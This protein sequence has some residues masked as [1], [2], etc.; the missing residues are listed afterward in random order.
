MTAKTEQARRRSLDQALASA[1]IEGHAPST[2][3]LADCERF[4]SGKMTTDE[5][6]ATSLAR[7]RAVENQAMVDDMVRDVA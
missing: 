5:I 3:F 6:R 2:A 1:R 7:A 4:V